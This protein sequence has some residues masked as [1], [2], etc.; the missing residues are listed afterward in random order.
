M[1]REMKLFIEDWSAFVWTYM[2][3]AILNIIP[4]IYKMAILYRLVKGGYNTV[5]RRSLH[6]QNHV[7]VTW[8]CHQM[9]STR[10]TSALEWIYKFKFVQITVMLLT[11]KS[12]QLS[13]KSCQNQT[14][15]LC[16]QKYA[17]DTYPK[18]IHHVTAENKPPVNMLHIVP[19]Y[20]R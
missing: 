5:S 8:P 7:I 2:G 17:Y 14:I 12:V 15:T 11:K 3:A 18:I 10:V 1:W 9:T 20:R 19:S 16:R 13:I 6:H 4:K